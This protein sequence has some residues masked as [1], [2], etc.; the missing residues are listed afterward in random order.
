MESF[1]SDPQSKFLKLIAFAILEQESQGKTQSQAEE[2][3]GELMPEVVQTP[4]P[5]AL[6]GRSVLAAVREG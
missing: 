3:M 2:Q 1:T 6:G 5:Y 4:V